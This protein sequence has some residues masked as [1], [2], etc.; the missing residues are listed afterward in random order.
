MPLERSFISIFISA[1]NVKRDPNNIATH[2]NVCMRQQ[3]VKSSSVS[4][5]PGIT[6]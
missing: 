5:N 3:A 2:M 4:A 6:M 1:G